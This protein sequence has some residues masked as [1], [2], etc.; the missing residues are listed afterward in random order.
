MRPLSER[1][2]EH[3]STAELAGHRR[4]HGWAAE[5]AKLELEIDALREAYATE[6][7]RRSAQEVADH[8]ERKRDAILLR[9]SRLKTAI[10]E[11]LNL[12]ES[13]PREQ[14]DG[15]AVILRAALEGGDG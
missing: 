5:I 15:M 13:D 14:G 1:V 10:T 7:M 12:L 8:L 9:E 11:A 4:I 6:Q 2:R 3:A